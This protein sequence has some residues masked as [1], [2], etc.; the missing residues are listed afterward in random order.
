[1]NTEKQFE[2]LCVNTIRTLAI[3]AVE[4]AESGHPGMPM[5]AAPMAH[6]LWSKIMRYNP[7][8]PGWK[9]RD[10]FVLS[11][12]HGCMLQYAMLHLTGYDLTLD[13]IKSFRQLGS[14]TPGH[15]EYGL[16]P[17]IEVTTGPL[18]QGFAN[19][20]GMAI[21]QRFLAAKYN[22]PGFT[23]FDYNIYG[24]VSDGDLMEGISAESAS[25]AG[26]L[27]LGNIIYLYDSNQISIEGSTGITFTDDTG[28]RFDAYGWHVQ[29]VSDGN[30]TEAIEIA[31]VAAKDV[32][33]KPSLI[34]VKTHIAYGSPNKQDKESSHGSPLGKEEVKLTKE[35]YGWDPEKQFYIPEE[36]SKFYREAI[37]RG[38]AEENKWNDIYEKYST[39][40]KEFSREYEN[41]A[42]GTIDP[43]WD[44]ILPVFTVEDKAIETRK[45]SGKVINVLA[46]HLPN[47]IGGSAD[48][49]PSN[50]TMIKGSPSYSA[51]DYAGRNFHFG[52]REHSMAAELN[53]ISLTGGITAFGGTFLIF[54]DYM[55]PAIRLAAIMKLRPIYVF[56]H[57]SIGL[58]ED[59]TTHQPV[60][61][62]CML[63]A[64]PNMTVI[65]P[66]DANE[67]VFAWKEALE[68]RTGPVAIILTRQKVP[69]TD[70]TKYATADNLKYGAYILS[71]SKDEAELILI[72]TGSEVQLAIDTK[73]M[74]SS[75][76][77]NIR[78]V[79]MPS[80][81]LFEK[82][83]DEYK[84][85]VLPS[86][87]KK[88]IAIEAASPM[89]W[90]KYAG[91]EGI[92]IGMETFGESAK[93]EDLEKHFGFTAQNVAAKAK[94]MMTGK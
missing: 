14:K 36:V 4:K 10:R 19:G 82:Q 72:A 17:G 51:M 85:K 83:S 70:R 25:F 66:A 35:F 64:I 15:P 21:G 41:A 9:N 91:D 45:A 18:G 61:Q 86:K 58:G 52:V 68:H 89:G 49:A 60:E 57:D 78:I 28:K 44:K 6:V 24:I 76:Y 59:G 22:K 56:T 29:T 13:D 7:A 33:D 88:R 81:E 54:S 69:V 73:E 42:K 34:I 27:K 90:H 48:L 63:R 71:E 62:L 12:G 5:G 30:D 39:K 23:V 8:N 26:H 92:I 47:L 50:D 37:S 67:T 3:D 20:V 65:R 55:K 38:V 40:Y 32:T 1:M 79:S 2:E 87:I 94:E 46:E 53:G 16:T 74:L 77:P 84:E 75:E 31:I 11:A 93:A 43:D 80:W